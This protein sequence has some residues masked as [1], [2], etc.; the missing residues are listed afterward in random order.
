MAQGRARVSGSRLN[1]Q[2]TSVPS[3]SVWLVSVANSTCRSGRSATSGIR[4][5]SDPLA[6]YP[7]ESSITGVR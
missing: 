2:K 5:G 1:G 4:H 6:R 3:S 7:S